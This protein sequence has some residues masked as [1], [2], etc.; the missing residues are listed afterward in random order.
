MERK[1]RSVSKDQYTKGVKAQASNLIKMFNNR[2]KKFD[3]KQSFF[4]FVLRPISN[5][6]K[7]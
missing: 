4:C 3:G 7:K 5:T 1:L 2:A 6:G